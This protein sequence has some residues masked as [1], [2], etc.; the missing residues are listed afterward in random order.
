MNRKIKLALVSIAIVSSA[1]A[2]DEGL[3]QKVEDHLYEHS[4]KY[5]GFDNPIKTSETISVPRASAQ[6]ASDLIKLASGLQAE[7]VSRKIADSSDMIAFWPNDNSPSHII[8]CVE[9]DNNQIGTYPSGKPKLA[10]S[11]QRLDLKTGEIKTLLRG[12]I[13][14]DGI[15]RTPW[16]TIVVTEET[17]DGGLY[18]ILN[19]LA[20]TELTLIAR[21]SSE[22]IDSNGVAATPGKIEYRG[23][24]RQVS[25]GRP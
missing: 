20:I 22:V 9:V 21:G 24:L 8:S 17:D 19:P 10:P 4:K 3:P 25:L 16:G 18:E 13:A 7:I 6:K 15:R 12:K 2:S 1:Q 5:F 14:C 23:T 11:L